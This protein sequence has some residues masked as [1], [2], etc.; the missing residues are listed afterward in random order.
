MENWTS[1]PQ[2]KWP[3]LTGLANR[4]RSSVEE[5]QM[6][7]Y[8]SPYTAENPASFYHYS[9]HPDDLATRRSISVY[10][11]KD[12]DKKKKN[13]RFPQ[14]RVCF[15]TMLLVSL[16]VAI[17][18]AVTLAIMLSDP[19]PKFYRTKDNTT[20]SK[21]FLKE[22][23][24]DF[25][26][27]ICDLMSAM[28]DLRDSSDQTRK[29]TDCSVILT[30]SP[31]NMVINVKLNVDETFIKSDADKI[32]SMLVANAFTLSSNSS[33]KKL[34]IAVPSNKTD[35]PT[36]M[37]SDSSIDPSSS[38]EMKTSSIPNIDARSSLDMETSVRETID[39]SESL[40]IEPSSTHE[41]DASTSVSIEDFT[42]PTASNIT[43]PS[44]TQDMSPSVSAEV[45]SSST[46]SS[47]K[48][49]SS[50]Y[51]QAILVPD[52]VS[53]GI[54]GVSSDSSISVTPDTFSSIALSNTISKTSAIVSSVEYPTSVS[55]SDVVPSVSSSPA[56][57]IS[58]DSSLS[59]LNTELTS[60]ADRL[61]SS[62]SLRDGQ[63]STDKTEFIRSKVTNDLS[64]YSVL[65]SVIISDSVSTKPII[66]ATAILQHVIDST[67]TS[68]P[69]YTTQY[70]EHISSSMM[71]SG[72][73]TDKEEI[74]SYAQVS[75]ADVPLITSYTPTDGLS[76]FP[77]SVST[78]E[79][80]NSGN[81]NRN[82]LKTSIEY[83]LESTVMATKALY[84]SPVISS[85]DVIINI[86]Q[87]P[88]A[89]SLSLSSSMDNP[90]LHSV[91][92]TQNIPS[93]YVASSMLSD[94]TPNVT[95]KT[96]AIESGTQTVS[97]NL[98][99]TKLS[100]TSVLYPSVVIHTPDMTSLQP[101]N[102]SQSV[103]ATA[104][105]TVPESP[106]MLRWLD[107][108]MFASENVM[109]TNSS[110]VVEMPLMNKTNDNETL[111]KPSSHVTVPVLRKN[112]TLETS[113]SPVSVP[114][115]S[116]NTDVINDN[117]THVTV[118]LLKPEVKL[119]VIG[120]TQTPT[121][122]TQDV[123]RAIFESEISN[124]AMGTANPE[125]FWD[126]ILKMVQ[127]TSTKKPNMG[128]TST[129]KNISS[130]SNISSVVD[131][132]ITSSYEPVTS[133]SLL[134]TGKAAL[135]TDTLSMSSVYIATSI[136]E[137]NDSI[138]SSVIHLK[139]SDSVVY[140]STPSTSLLSS[141]VYPSPTASS[142]IRATPVLTAEPGFKSSIEHSAITDTPVVTD[143][144]AT[145][146]RLMTASIGNGNDL[147]SSDGRRNA[148]VKLTN[149]TKHGE[150]LLSTTLDASDVS[151]SFVQDATLDSQVK[152]S[153]ES[154]DLVMKTVI[155]SSAMF[156]PSSTISAIISSQSSA[157]VTLS[158]DFAFYDLMPLS[159][160]SSSVRGSSGVFSSS[161]VSSK[162]I[163]PT[164]SML[165]Q[166][167][168]DDFD[169]YDLMPVNTMASSDEIS[170][171]KTES[172]EM[173]TDIF[174]PVH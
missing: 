128:V 19:H 67:V 174:L 21:D 131:E 11:L 17:A 55:I 112:V 110:S 150:M 33:V 145:V 64:S 39:A 13:S 149:D 161:I 69:V 20:L 165:Q 28:F 85:S 118:P 129:W 22:K 61:S 122:T 159:I 9:L 105:E 26:N 124:R 114:E 86:D 34:M 60:S 167:L 144:T 109:D 160:E 27:D 73:G 115:L 16:G 74:T 15:A 140:D 43:S 100:T 102:P 2:D 56:V 30:D 142:L 130:D 79:V 157:T 51:S 101:D 89:S 41:E 59:H 4:D 119:P 45:V 7:T 62:M 96:Q 52:T 108:T 76:Y 6:S 127:Y 146:Y 151:L 87:P 63:M 99:Q 116:N 10:S 163:S 139:S 173:K 170:P 143:S 153:S 104:T 152:T 18:V 50:S 36:E 126:N 29:V 82:I 38:V 94:V 83:G 95:L 68:H 162:D 125:D 117:I 90:P 123:G 46:I 53:V 81:I 164:S 65:N 132:T 121:S 14:C 111:D 3:R 154:S 158:D 72:Y 155:V 12:P 84:R 168:T 48:I 57:L 147:M 141:D 156:A 54:D 103:T 5:A 97:D 172:A 32:K 136:T 169:F 171:S 78:Y 44:T 120:T 37:Q 113:P 93:S 98:I 70:K 35:I 71:S 42:M 8:E 148:S 49:I 25:G 92:S 106:P 23:E 137:I 1:R 133:S 88:L 166:Q 80:R 138:S 107:T 77:S 40:G 91:F 47:S 75:A 58:L 31:G 134:L 66:T 24:A 135:S